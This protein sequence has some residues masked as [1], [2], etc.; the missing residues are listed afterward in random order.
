[1]DALKINA[2]IYRSLGV[3][4]EDE[5]SLMKTMKYL[6]K[7]AKNLQDDPTCMSKEEYFDN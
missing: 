4:A 2:E 7:L 6:R 1:M 5:P 3:I